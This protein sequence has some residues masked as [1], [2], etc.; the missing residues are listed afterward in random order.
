MRTKNLKTSQMILKL[1]KDLLNRKVTYM[2][3]IFFLNIHIPIEIEISEH[4]INDWETDNAFYNGIEHFIRVLKLQLLE[5]EIVFDQQL[6]QNRILLNRVFHKS[7]SSKL[8]TDNFQEKIMYQ[9]LLL[10][11]LKLFLEEVNNPMTPIPLDTL[12]VVIDVLG[13]V[14]YKVTQTST[15]K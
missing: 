4:K 9:Q 1:C 13:Y 14:R 6:N 5:S 8:T 15:L 2:D 3:V 10:Y 7:V 11:E 12:N